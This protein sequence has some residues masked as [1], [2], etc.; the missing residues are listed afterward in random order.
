MMLEAGAGAVNV[1]DGKPQQLS[2]FK[3]AQKRRIKCLF[4]LRNSQCCGYAR[5]RIYLA[6]HIRIEKA[7][8]DLG[9]WKFTKIFN[10]KS[11]VGYLLCRFVFDLFYIFHVKI[12]LFVTLKSD[13]DPDPQWSGSLDPDPH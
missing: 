12:Q 4:L 7:D 5:I 13:Q 11:F 9:A 10:K 1:V 6:V 8:S 3:S 2:L